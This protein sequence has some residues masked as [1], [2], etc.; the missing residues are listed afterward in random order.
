MI[1]L[2][3]T[4]DT[5][6]KGDTNDSVANFYFLEFRQLNQIMSFAEETSNKQRIFSS[7]STSLSSL[8]DNASTDDSVKMVSKFSISK[9]IPNIPDNYDMKIND[10]MD[11]EEIEEDEEYNNDDKMKNND[12]SIGQRKSLFMPLLYEM[13]L[14]KNKNIHGTV[15]GPSNENFNL[16]KA[17]EKLRQALSGFDTNEKTIIEVTVGHN[18]FQRQQIMSTY[19][20][21]YSKILMDDVRDELGGFFLDTISSLFIPTHFYLANLLHQSLNQMK[22][23]RNAYRIAFRNTLECDIAIK[24]EGIFGV[25]L[26]L[27]L[28]SPR[29]E[30]I[31]ENDMLIEKHVDL[32]IKDSD[33]IEE[34]SHN[35]VLFEKLFIGHSWRHIAAVIDK[36]DTKLGGNGYFRT[37]I[38]YNR[39]IP[40]D[41]KNMLHTIVK[42]SHNTQWYFAEKLYNA[43]CSSKPDHETIIRIIVSR[44]E[45]DLLDICYEYR[46]HYRHS[47]I[48]DIRKICRVTIKGPQQLEKGLIVG[49]RW[50]IISK[51]GEGGCG[52]VYKVEDIQTFAKAALKAESNFVEGGSILKLEVQILKRLEGRKY[53]IQLFQS[54]KKETYSYMVMTLLG[55]SLNQLFKQC[56][57]CTVSTQVRVGINILHGLKQLH[58]VGYIHR[59]V[60]PANL[61]IGRRGQAIHIIHILDFGLS[62][63]YV[64]RNNGSVKLRMP[65]TNTLFRGTIRYCSANTHTRNEQGRPDDLWSMVYVL[66]EMRGSLPWDSIRGKDEIG[67]VKFQTLDTTLCSNSPKELLDIT[68]HLRTLDYY[69][70]PNY[71]YIYERLY[72]VM[73]KCNYKFSDPYDWEEPA[74]TTMSSIRKGLTYVSRSLTRVRPHTPASA[75][76]ISETRSTKS[77]MTSAATSEVTNEDFFTQADFESNETGF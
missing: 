22:A 48:V 55:R 63:E 61:A 42:I 67:R 13:N 64:I 20:Y 54:A 9:G 34:I 36:I 23:I 51:L 41:I 27:L 53:V 40:S 56:P 32:I 29:N 45:I 3:I 1:V 33:G 77:E 49:K 4:N 26:Q 35:V 44:S 5:V 21:L 37:Q 12:Q 47:L 15:I 30:Q 58:E 11:E 25:M 60:K 68:S 8:T 39:N 38:I 69:T 71:A 43:L 31:S 52:A 10:E 28:C 62:R 75:D 70:R 50:R 2:R 66:V 18:N 6:A 17:S 65:R 73:Q 76:I 14:N 72:K 19:E 7:S 24:I 59:D 74:F 57:V 16:V 46:K